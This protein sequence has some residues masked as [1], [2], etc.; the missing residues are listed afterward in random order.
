MKQKLVKILKIIP[1]GKWFIKRYMHLKRSIHFSKMGTPRD[2][3]T[4]IYTMN[5][6]GNSESISGH[7][8]S[9]E[10]TENIRREIPELLRRFKINSFLDAPC[11]DYNWFR[12][13]RRDPDFTYIGGDIVTELIRK[14][15]EAYEN[16]NTR[17]VDLDI[18]RE[19]L[20]TVELW[21]CRDCLFHFS[22]DDI[23]STIDN[24]LKSDIQYLLTS[25]HSECRKNKNITTGDF[26]L[27]NLELAPFNFGKPKLHIADWIPGFPVRYLALWDR[28]ELAAAMST[29]SHFRR[30]GKSGR[31]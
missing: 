18:I 14:N 2:V 15:R 29:N 19:K 24:F 25:T 20:P 28:E 31:G 17:F 12:L 23:F 3:F 8:S 7:G 11:G 1:G 21:L 10:Y 4:S 6:W 5:N 27:I 16:Q 9:A 30:R 22:Y 26:R 13:I